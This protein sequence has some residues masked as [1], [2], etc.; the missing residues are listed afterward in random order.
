[1]ARGWES[2]SVEDQQAEAISPVDKSK[3]K[4]T[5]AQLAKRR[6]EDGL[7]LTRK[8]ILQQLEAAQHP[9][10]R[11]MLENALADVNSRLAELS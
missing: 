8:R 7:V 2:K 11:N 10:H 9:Q 4:L 6:E 3:P 5:Q 1:M